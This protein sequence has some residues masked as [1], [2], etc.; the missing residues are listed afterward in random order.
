MDEVL[1]GLPY[2]Y[3]YIDDILVASKDDDSHKQHLREVFRRLSHCGLRLNLDKCVFGAPS[4][5]FLGHN[6][7]A[8]GI[9]PLPTKISAIQDFP[10]PTSMKQLRR[11][12]G[13]INFYR[14]FI[15]KCS[16]I[17]QPLTNLLQ[18]KNRNISLETDALHTF[19]AA[20]TALVNFTKL[21]YIKDD[22]K[23]HLALTTDAS[24][25][26]VGAVVE[27][28]YDCPAVPNDSTDLSCPRWLSSWTQRLNRPQLTSIQTSSSTQRLDL[29]QRPSS[30]AQLRT[31]TTW[32]YQLTT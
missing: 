17:L 13:M 18:R 6:I 29:R 32:L 11:F 12:I 22:P 27:Q 3:A 10:T 25:A 30:N 15:P 20:K 23:M 21:S 16:T 7:D 9:T 24:D 26:G 5:E 28:E 31:S 14:R 4:I 2:V 19:N 8:E 1:R